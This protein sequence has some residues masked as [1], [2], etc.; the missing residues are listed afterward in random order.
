MTKATIG[1]YSQVVDLVYTGLSTTE[2][3]KRIGRSNP[4]ILKLIRFKNDKHVIDKITCNN[5]YS[6]AKG[7]L[8]ST[9]HAKGKTYE[10]IYGDRADEMK[11]KRSKWLKENNIRKFATRISKPQAIL[12]SIVKSY[13]QQAELEY[14]V[15]TDDNKRIWLDIAIPNLKINIEYDGIYWHTKN[16]TTISLSDEKRDKFLR[17]IGWRVFRIRSVRN[18][19]EEELKNEFNKLQLI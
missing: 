11:K 17:S 4:T 8:M 1:L 2:I 18:L 13:F 14:E 12:Y 6:R 3:S 15:I 5:N 9:G 19:T 7:L 16:K 10:E